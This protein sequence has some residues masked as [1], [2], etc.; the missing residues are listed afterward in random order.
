M[1]TQMHLPESGHCSEEQFWEEV[2]KIGWGTKGTKYDKIK[3]ELLERWTPAFCASFRE[4]YEEANSKIYKLLFDVVEGLGD[5][6]YGDFIAHI[7]GLGKAEYERV[8]EDPSLANKRAQDGDFKESFA[9]CLPYI[10]TSTLDFEDFSEKAKAKSRDYG[11]EPNSDAA[12][13]M[14]F[15]CAT[16]GD[17]HQLDPEYYQAFAQMMLPE[18]EAFLTSDLCSKSVSEPAQVVVD[19]LTAVSGGNVQV[20]LDRQDEFQKAQES[21]REFYSGL[22]SNFS[23]KLQEIDGISGYGAENLGRDI[24]RYMTPQ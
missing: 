12:I 15:I 19:V 18:Y 20:M 14:Q 3:R 11:D 23:Q 16:K 17:W 6:G 5:D 24:T 8:L 4:R 10:P 2:A 7:V 9:Y 21:L 13:R 1:E 22:R